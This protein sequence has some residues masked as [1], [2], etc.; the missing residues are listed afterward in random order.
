MNDEELIERY[1]KGESLADIA[2]AAN[3]RMMTIS[4][5][6]AKFRPL[7]GYR[8]RPMDTAHPIRRLAAKRKELAIQLR[9]KGLSTSEIAKRTGYSEHT[10][11]RIA[12]PVNRRYEL[13][14]RDIEAQLDKRS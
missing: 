1:R 9:E 3:R 4:N 5:R 11:N 14:I 6:L 13:L 12:P 8:Q 2:A 10:V 7:I